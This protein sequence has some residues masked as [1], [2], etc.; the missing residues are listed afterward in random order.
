M[1][2]AVETSAQRVR[3]HLR[4]PIPGSRDLLMETA[5][6]TV[7]EIVPNFTANVRGIGLVPTLQTGILL[8]AGGDGRLAGAA[9]A[10][11]AQAAAT[12]LT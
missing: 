7:S 11:Y 5:G 4:R 10:D 3:D 9:R 12:V 8:G 1:D 6:N 2:G